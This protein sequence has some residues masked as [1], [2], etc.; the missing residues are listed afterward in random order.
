MKYHNRMDYDT[1]RYTL[2]QVYIPGSTGVLPARDLYTVGLNGKY[3]A[4]LIGV[5][6]ADQASA[7]DNRLIRISS[8][9]FREISGNML[10]S[11]AICNRHEHNMGNPQG[12]YPFVL[13]VVGGRIDITLSSSVAYTNNPN[14]SF[15]F[16]ILTLEVCPIKNS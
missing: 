3:K 6:W 8:D 2:V 12:A 4:R 1:E 15:D 13:D 14:Q 10:S 5:S 16:C 7:K 9:C 11:I